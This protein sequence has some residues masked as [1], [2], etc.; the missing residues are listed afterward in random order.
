VSGRA[1]LI[2][3]YRARHADSVR[4]LVAPALEREW[5]VVWWA[6]DE[7]A[8]GLGPITVGSGPGPRLALLNEVLQRA[9][10]QEEWVAVSDDDLTFVRGDVAG[11]VTLA[12]RAGLDLA[13]PAR[14]DPGV[15]HRITTF[16]RLSR[17]RRTS[18][19]EIGPLFVVGPRWRDRILPF[20]ESRGMGWG[21]ELDWLE[22]FRDGCELGIVDAV[23]VRHDGARGEEYDDAGE[24]ERVHEELAA[25]GYRSW[26]DVQVTLG[27]WR[28][29]QR[30]PGWQAEARD[31]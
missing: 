27:T 19:V 30:A 2:G 20:P 26:A 28:P 15:D 10:V 29:W 21:L 8:D 11:L 1:A 25:L 16:R 3:V 24:I 4:R 17:A 13:Q 31:A 7:P 23:R 5:K 18:F 12:E 9:D 6:L 22:L 14:S